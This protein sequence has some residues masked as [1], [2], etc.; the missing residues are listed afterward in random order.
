MIMLLR[1][2]EFVRILKLRKLKAY[3]KQHVVLNASELLC[4]MIIDKILRLELKFIRQN[5]IWAVME[6]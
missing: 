3:E 2:Q 4:Q 5:H 6:K 1:S